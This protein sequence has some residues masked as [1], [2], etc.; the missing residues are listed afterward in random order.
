MDD[1]GRERRGAW[2]YRL[3]WAWLRL[4]RHPDTWEPEDPYHDKYN[5][6]I[7]GLPVPGVLVFPFNRR[8]DRQMRE[9]AW[10]ERNAMIAEFERRRGAGAEAAAAAVA[11]DLEARAARFRARRAGAPSAAGTAGVTR[12]AGST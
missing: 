2:W 5:L 8:F 11:E 6:L 9:E 10:R 1:G 7:P 12:V 3:K 4:I